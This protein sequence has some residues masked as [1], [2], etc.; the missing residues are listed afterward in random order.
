MVVVY[1][2]AV[3]DRAIHEECGQARE[4]ERRGAKDAKKKKKK[5]LFLE[6]RTPLLNHWSC[7]CSVA[8]V[9]AGGQ[10]E[11]HLICLVSS[12]N[13]DF[14]LQGQGL[15]QLLRRGASWCDIGLQ[16]QRTTRRRQRVFLVF[17]FFSILSLS[18]PVSSFPPR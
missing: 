11:A 14:I 10:S 3:N 6:R 16:K 7:V 13:C 8:A 5:K 9:A 12:Y 18:P 4:K 17:C 2:P 1:F 15:L